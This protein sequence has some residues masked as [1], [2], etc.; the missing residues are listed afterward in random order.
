LKRNFF[1]FKR[2]CSRTSYNEIRRL[3]RGNLQKE[4]FILHLPGSANFYNT[5]AEICCKIS[6]KLRQQRA[7]PNVAQQIQ[8]V[9]AE[10]Q[11]LHVMQRRIYCQG[12]QWVLFL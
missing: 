5:A 8:M 4:I 11:Y 10:I 12:R 6:S 9:I 1:R 3:S 7:A 2:L